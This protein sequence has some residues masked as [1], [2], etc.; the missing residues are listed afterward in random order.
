M[1]QIDLNLFL[2]IMQFYYR[3][4]D[5][6]KLF[7]EQIRLKQTEF[8]YLDDVFEKHSP[9]YL[10][11]LYQ[12]KYFYW[13]FK[14]TNESR[15]EIIFELNICNDYLKRSCNKNACINFH[16]CPNE[17]FSKRCSD[18]MCSLEHSLDTQHNIKAI[19]KK[20]LVTVN[21][22]IILQILKLLSHKSNAKQ[23]NINEVEINSNIVD[24]FEN[25]SK[26][27]QNYQVKLESFIEHLE[28]ENNNLKIC[29][30][31]IHSD[32]NVT[33]EKLKFKLDRLTIEE[34]REK[35]LHDEI[36]DETKEN[37]I[38]IDELESK[39]YMT[40]NKSKENEIKIAKF[41]VIRAHLQLE[42][43]KINNKS[44]LDCIEI[45]NRHL[46]E[47]KFSTID[48]FKENILKEISKCYKF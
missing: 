29:L 4:R 42:Q 27:I 3:I 45:I 39:I 19:Q 32:Y 26:K 12:Y 28:C 15:V 41:S 40:Q 34:T 8:I 30:K 7:H 20:G 10:F 24:H 35:K 25:F 18:E 9:D 36:C 13:F 11:Y 2:S 16:I 23:E 38:K 43:E 33:M 37:L 31:Q 14:V 46:V 1:K 22:S 21:R 47:E 5:P 6:F 48:E 44:L 17:C